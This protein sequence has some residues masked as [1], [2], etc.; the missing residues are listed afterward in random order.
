VK[1]TLFNRQDFI[2]RSRFF[3]PVYI[4]GDSSSAQRLGARFKVSGYP[5]MISSIRTARRSRACPAR[6]TP[7]STCACS[8]WE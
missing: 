8:R 6:S 3:I 1:A 7:T 4:D 2:D 5:T